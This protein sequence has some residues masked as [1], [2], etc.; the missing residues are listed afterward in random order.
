MEATS[1]HLE[2]G[3]A[4][5]QKWAAFQARGYTRAEVE[6]SPTMRE[7]IHRLKTRE[8]DDLLKAV[9]DQL[10]TARSAAILANFLEA[11]TR[12]GP[13]GLPR[14]IELHAH[15]PIRYV[16]DMLAWVHQAMAGEREFLESLFG[17]K[18]DGR[19]PG[20]VRP[21]YPVRVP[22]DEYEKEED[23][24][25][26]RALMDKNLEGCGRPL[27]IR[28]Q[29]TIRS[30]EGSSLMAYKI[31]NL[32]AFYRLT[33]ERTIGRDAL[34]S[35]VLLD[36]A[37]SAT[38]TFHSTLDSSGRSLLR[39]IQPPPSD[40][41]APLMLRDA[42]STLREILDVHNASLL[43]ELEQPDA[44]EIDEVLSKGLDPALAMCERMG[45]LRP[46][47]WDRDVFAV[48]CLSF[49]QVRL[50]LSSYDEADTFCLAVCAAA[51]RALCCGSYTRDSYSRTKACRQL[52]R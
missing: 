1:S 22:K 49:V 18:A 26:I 12:G 41:S 6:V 5:L 35:K 32:I 24:G 3:Y 30:Q 36:I 16:G 48:N 4:K 9:L 50:H 51:F 33:I 8:Q 15:D 46:G 45:E 7:V 43:D 20:S 38:E 42:L 34:M 25:R 40:L 21:E 19:L 28:V 14:P 44:N 52:S 47:Q 11:L 29:Q 31:S 10:A 23:E 27:K 17:V 2:A 37:A 13:S 39:F